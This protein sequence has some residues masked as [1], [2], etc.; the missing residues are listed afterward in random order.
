MTTIPPCWRVCIQTIW[1]STAVSEQSPARELVIHFHA[2]VYDKN[3]TLCRT[4]LLLKVFLS[5]SKTEHP[6]RK[7]LGRD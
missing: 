5:Y 7:V 1:D 6:E 3:V 4:T 2:T